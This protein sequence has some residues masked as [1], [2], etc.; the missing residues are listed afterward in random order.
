MR[1]LKSLELSDKCDVALPLVSATRRDREYLSLV[2]SSMHLLLGG[3][4]MYCLTDARRYQAKF[5]LDRVHLSA[6]KA[7]S[8]GRAS[9]E[10]L[11]S[12]A[13]VIL[14]V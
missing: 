8:A 13:H 6:V 7:C 1:L 4:M 9:R 12:S 5:S 14:L 3:E 2:S 10:D 11:S